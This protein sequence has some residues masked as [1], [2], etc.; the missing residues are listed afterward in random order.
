M[1]HEQI[2]NFKFKLQGIYMGKTQKIAD[3]GANDVD[4]HPSSEKKTSMDVKRTNAS[5]ADL[6]AFLREKSTRNPKV[7]AMYGSKDSF[8][9]HPN[10]IPTMGNHD[11]A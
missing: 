5:V 11:G 10:G 6:E 8:D 9:T 3:T 2:S 4:T 7:A 1:I